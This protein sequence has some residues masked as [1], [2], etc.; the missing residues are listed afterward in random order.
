MVAFVKIS[1]RILTQQE[2]SILL[3]QNYN[4]LTDHHI[5]N[6]STISALFKPLVWTLVHEPRTFVDPSKYSSICELLA[7]SHNINKAKITQTEE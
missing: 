5:Q 7:L 2:E 1:F 4:R 3:L 6:F